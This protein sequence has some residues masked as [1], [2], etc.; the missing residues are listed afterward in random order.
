MD[1]EKSGRVFSILLPKR[2][3]GY[4]VIKKRGRLSHSLVLLTSGVMLQYDKR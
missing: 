2:L 1:S 4:T 3:I